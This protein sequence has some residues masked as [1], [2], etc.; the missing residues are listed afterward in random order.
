MKEEAEE[1]EKEGEDKGEREE[2]KEEAKKEEEEQEK[3]E[4]ENK[5]KKEKKKVLNCYELSRFRTLSVI[6]RADLAIFLSN[7]LLSVLCTNGFVL[8]ARPIKILKL[9]EFIFFLYFGFFHF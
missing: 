1:E 2:E 8:E 7:T 6:P 5:R 9:T 3:K 4:K